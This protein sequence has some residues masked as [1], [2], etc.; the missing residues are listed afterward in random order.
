MCSIVISRSV[1]LTSKDK[2]YRQRLKVWSTCSSDAQREHLIQI[3]ISS[4][5]EFYFHQHFELHTALN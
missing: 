1:Q 2:E 5:W 3:I 4:W